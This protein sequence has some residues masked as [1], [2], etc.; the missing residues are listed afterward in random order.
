MYKEDAR[1]KKRDESPDDLS[2]LDRPTIYTGPAHPEAT[3]TVYGLAAKNLGKDVRFCQV[4]RSGQQARQRMAGA[5]FKAGN[6]C[7]GIRQGAGIHLLAAESFFERPPV[8]PLGLGY[9]LS[10]QA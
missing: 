10:R 5:P 4:R 6:Q 8:H 1:A 7:R 3:V 2:Y 9:V